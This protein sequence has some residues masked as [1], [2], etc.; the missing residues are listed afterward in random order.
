MEGGLWAPH[1]QEDW[2]SSETLFSAGKSAPGLKADDEA[3][4]DSLRLRRCPG[5]RSGALSCLL[6]PRGCPHPPSRLSAPSFSLHTNTCASLSTTRQHLEQRLWPSSRPVATGRGWEGPG[7]GWGMEE[8]PPL[9]PPGALWPGGH[10][11]A[12][13]QVIGPHSSEDTPPGDKRI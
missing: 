10:G 11:A 1:L 8:G 2:S 13:S 6:R 5:G 7:R 4:V 3:V 9:G 12:L